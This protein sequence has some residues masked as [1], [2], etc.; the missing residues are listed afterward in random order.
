M[1]K[2]EISV[3]FTGDIGFDRYMYRKWEDDSLIS[4]E[5]LGFLRGAD[6][7]VANV[8]GP[9]LKAEQ[10]TVK[11]GI[12]V[13]HD[14][15]WELLGAVVKRQ[16]RRGIA[17]A[18]DELVQLEIG[19]IQQ[20]GDQQLPTVGDKAAEPLPGKHAN[21]LPAGAALFQARLFQ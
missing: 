13:L 21:M 16:I 9:L 7:V 14:E 1:D 4:E 10:N 5:V 12:R 19:R 18:D 2:K 15:V 20:L 17:Q 11:G 6:H 3:A 8:E